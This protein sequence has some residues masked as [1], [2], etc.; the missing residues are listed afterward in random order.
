MEDHSRNLGFGF[1]HVP[2]K[3]Q[4]ELVKLLD[5]LAHHAKVNNMKPLL[6]FDTH[7]N[8]DDGLYID[9]ENVFIDWNSLSKKLRA[10][11]IHTGNNLAVVG[12]TCYGLHAIKPI[13]L[14]TAT[15]FYLLLSPEEQ[16]SVGFLEK[17]IPSFY[18]SLFELGSIDSAFTHHISEEFKFYHCEK[19]LFIVIA[20]YISQQCKG[21]GGAARREKLLTEIMSQGMENTA[22]NRK[23]VRKIL[24]DGLRPDQSLND[25][26]AGRFLIGR[27]C[28]FNISELLDFIESS[29]AA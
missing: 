7:G 14:S 2:I 26:F 16:V 3:S 15:P 18:R 22:E 24:K 10:I 8:K 23:K 20:R 17:N 21:K 28:S 5:E 19:M 27:Q 1:Q 29:D 13:T 6:H 9:G 25:R 4:N 11:N 12:A